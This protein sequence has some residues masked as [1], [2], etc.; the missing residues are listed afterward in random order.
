MTAFF[1][2]P[3]LL[4]Q[5]D[6]FGGGVELFV[7]RVVAVIVGAVVGAL[8]ATLGLR[9]VY[10]LFGLREV[11]YPV[12]VTGRLS[13]A[14]L[15]AV[16]VWLWAFSG[17]GNGWLGGGGGFWPFGAP[18]GSGNKD[19]TAQGKDKD[20]DKDV[21]K[22]T[23][24]GPEVLVVHMLGGER[25]KEQRFYIL[26]K[27]KPATFEEIKTSIASA[28]SKNANLKKV[29]IRVYQD[30]VD[31]FNPA[32]TALREW[33]ESQDLTPTLATPKGQAP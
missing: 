25:V 21:A 24:E 11:H 27:G 26:E 17:G 32:V 31:E 9:F 12:R 15:G 18:H 10:R 19:N 2:M 3:A 29:E 14:L 28:R 8:A 33:V 22:K 16:L 7:W 5:T 30:S 23:E 4:A 13:G 20:K 1:P 6:L